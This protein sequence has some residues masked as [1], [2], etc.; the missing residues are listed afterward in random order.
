MNIAALRTE[1]KELQAGLVELAGIAKDT[2]L[3]MWLIREEREYL[4]SVRDAN[5]A[6]D[7]AIEHELTGVTNPEE[8]GAYL[9]YADQLE[10]GVL[11]ETA[12][13]QAHLETIIADMKA[14]IKEL[15]SN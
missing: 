2:A 10:D 6:C 9:K 15:D 13:H 11:Q 1:R 7:R 8:F 3:I 4:H 12:L 14:R 5:K